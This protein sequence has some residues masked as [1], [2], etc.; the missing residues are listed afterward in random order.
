MLN[1]THEA[2]VKAKR[3]AMN[4]KTTST[5]QTKVYLGCGGL[6]LPIRILKGG[7]LD[8]SLYIFV[9]NILLVNHINI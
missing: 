4:L 6:L 2:N 1:N 9:L 3:I 8:P 5:Y 7:S